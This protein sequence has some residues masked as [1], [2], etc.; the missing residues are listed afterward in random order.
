MTHLVEVVLRRGNHVT[1]QRST[2]TGLGN[3][4][5]IQGK[6]VTLGILT[7]EVLSLGTPAQLALSRQY[8]TGNLAIDDFVDVCGITSVQSLSLGLDI[9]LLQVLLGQL[10][11]QVSGRSG[12]SNSINSSSSS[13]VSCDSQCVSNYRSLATQGSILLVQLGQQR[14]DFL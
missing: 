5:G 11:S 7:T 12:S 2:A 6:D 10:G 14:I 1:L 13:R 4:Q 9:A 8:L 3:L